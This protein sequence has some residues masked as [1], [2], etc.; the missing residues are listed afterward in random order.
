MKRL[1]GAVL[2]LVALQSCAPMMAEDTSVSVGIDFRSAPPPPIMR[3]DRRPMLHEIRGTSVYVVDDASY[4]V[5]MYGGS[6]YL[7][8]AGYWYRSDSDESAFVAIDL[9]AVPRP[10]MRVPDRHWRHGRPYDR[11][12][13]RYRRGYDNS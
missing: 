3:W 9:R 5:F 11:Y 7:Y 10:V 12:D 13:R 2:V 8:N 1:L 6:Y 4:D